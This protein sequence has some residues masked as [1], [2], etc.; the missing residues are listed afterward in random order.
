[1]EESLLVA[2]LIACGQA[3]AYAEVGLAMTASK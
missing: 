1:M 3:V 2:R